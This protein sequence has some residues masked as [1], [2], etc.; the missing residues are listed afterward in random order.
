MEKVCE[1][2]VYGLGLRGFG[3]MGFWGLGF[4][5]SHARVLGLE[6]R[7]WGM[8]SGNY[9]ALKPSPSSP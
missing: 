1:L 5:G 9:L 7:D 8:M 4:G 3:A 2:R 6:F